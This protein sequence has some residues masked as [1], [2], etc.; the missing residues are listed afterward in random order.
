MGVSQL[1]KSS[2]SKTSRCQ[3]HLQN[4]GSIRA[5]GVKHID[6]Y[7]SLGD[8]VLSTV[9]IRQRGSSRFPPETYWGARYTDSAFSAL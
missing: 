3:K 6:H 4:G 1:L 8:T 2:D 7:L 9:T 5:V